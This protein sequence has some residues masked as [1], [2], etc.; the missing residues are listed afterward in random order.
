MKLKFIS[1]FILAGILMLNI[2]FTQK[3]VHQYFYENYVNTLIFMGLN[4]VLFPIALIV[5]KRD[6]KKGGERA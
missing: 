6:R 1:V 3:M 4:I 5:Y 2:V